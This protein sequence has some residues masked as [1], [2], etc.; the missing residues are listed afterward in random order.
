MATTEE[1]LMS[2]LEAARGGD[3][4]AADELY[5]RLY[6]EL[7]RLARA[8]LGRGR[9]NHATLDTTALV[10]EAYLRLQ[11]AEGLEV[12]SER[13]FLNLAAKV[14]RALVVDT[15][16]RKGAQKRGAALRA[17]WP[18]G[19]EPG[20]PQPLSPEELL[21]L[22]GALADLERESPRLAHLVELRFFAGLDLAHIAA[23]LEVSERTVKRD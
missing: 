1:P 7:R 15:L 2:L 18:E 16:R 6:D 14:M 12:A 9:R 23:L 8:Q 11:P 21:A 4:A 10:H 20:A 13:H 17:D 19:F 5:R 22:D 3:A